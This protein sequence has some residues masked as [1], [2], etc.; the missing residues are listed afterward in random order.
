MHVSKQPALTLAHC[1]LEVYRNWR[2]TP[3]HPMA[4]P[5]MITTITT[6]IHTATAMA[7]EDTRFQKL[8][9]H[10][11]TDRTS[12]MTR[13]QGLRAFRT[14]DVMIETGLSQPLVVDGDL[15]GK[16]PVRLRIAPGALKVCVPESFLEDPEATH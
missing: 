4:L 14:H 16:T 13:T 7:M 15:C 11:M 12:Q 2:K 3:A 10:R 5:A 6:T 8:T 1:M 9:H